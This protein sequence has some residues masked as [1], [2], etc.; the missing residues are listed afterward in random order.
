MD[1]GCVDDVQ[2]LASNASG[3]S[4]FLL[5]NTSMGVITHTIAPV[6]RHPFFKIGLSSSVFS[7]QVARAA[8]H[9]Y[10][11]LRWTRLLN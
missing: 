1:V 6:K 11:V 5:P 9:Y 3:Y 7:Q 10:P 2:K 8:S 4:V